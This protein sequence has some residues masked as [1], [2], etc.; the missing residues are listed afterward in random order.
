M[1]QELDLHAGHVDP[2][3]DIPSRTLCI[4]THSESVSYISED[5]RA[6]APS[7][8]VR[9]KPQR[10]GPAACGVAFISGGAVG[11]AH[12]TRD[13]FFRQAPLLLHISV[14]PTHPPHDDQS[15]AVVTGRGPY[16]SR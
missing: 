11:G 9:A 2:G 8:P 15:S 16:P 5:V 3:W 6:S 7:C 12:D 1:V 10:V 4:P 13:Q 14:A